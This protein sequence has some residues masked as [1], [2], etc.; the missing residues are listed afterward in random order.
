MRG[1]KGNKYAYRNRK[2]KHKGTGR[3]VEI[4]GD[5]R[6]EDERREGVEEYK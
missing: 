4:R 6:A 2:E 5:E 3:K 1:G